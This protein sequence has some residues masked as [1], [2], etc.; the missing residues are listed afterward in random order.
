MKKN[1]QNHK[2]LESLPMLCYLLQK[3]T[4]YITGGIFYICT[5]KKLFS[6]NSIQ[7]PSSYFMV[8][9]FKSVPQGIRTDDNRLSCATYCLW[10]KTMVKT[11]KRQWKI[12]TTSQCHEARLDPHVPNAR[13]CPTY[14]ASHTLLAHSFLKNMYIMIIFSIRTQS[15]T[16]HL[17]VCILK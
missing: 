9:T 11:V 13:L 10:Q 1:T 16:I 15:N 8:D 2:S 5:I 6:Y 4:N 14:C 12:N 7:A 3:Y 17:G